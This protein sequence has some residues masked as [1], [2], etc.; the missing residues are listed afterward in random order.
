[1][2]SGSSTKDPVKSTTRPKTTRGSKRK[3]RGYEGSSAAINIS[4]RRV[5]IV[6]PKGTKYG[7]QAKRRD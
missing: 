6:I 2:E 4:A 3:E 1:M 5:A 7:P